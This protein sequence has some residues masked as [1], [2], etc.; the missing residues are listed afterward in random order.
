MLDTN[1][2]DYSVVYACKNSLFGRYKADWAQI[3]MR[4][5]HHHNSKEFKDIEKKG[6]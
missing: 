4:K 2:D 3:L 5:N 6:K 1:Y